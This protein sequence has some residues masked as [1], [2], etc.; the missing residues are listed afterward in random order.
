MGLKIPRVYG[1]LTRDPELAKTLENGT[2][3]YNT[4]IAVRGMR[5]EDNEV[6]DGFM[7]LTLFV[8][9]KSKMG[10]N[11]IK[12]ARKGNRILLDID[13]TE[14]VWTPEGEDT[15]YMW[16]FNITGFE[17]VETKAEAEGAASGS[18]SE[19]SSEPSS[20]TPAASAA[21]EPVAA[22]SGEFNPFE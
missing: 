16:K 17:L 21:S 11:F 4:T 20:G 7:F 12:Y 22:G 8:T 3:I 9:E 5:Y 1:R 15:R 19:A 10:E 6:K 13:M 2:K 18:S 14:H